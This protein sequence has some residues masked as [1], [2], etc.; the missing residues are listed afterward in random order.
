M[1]Q[2]HLVFVS[3]QPVPSLTPLIDPAVGAR[4]AILVH[5]PERR[6]H[7]L[8]LQ[9]ALARHAVSAQLHP[10]RDGYDL[11]GLREELRD[12]AARHPQ[13]V[14]AN[15]TGGT[16]L[17][18]IAAWEC[19]NR[20]GDRLYYIDIRH[21][22]L[23][24]LRPEAPEQPVADRVQLETYLLAHGRRISPQQPL[25]RDA[26]E[27]SRLQLARQQ[28]LHLARSERK[29]ASEGGQWLEDLVFAEALDLKRSDRKVQDVA[30]QFRLEQSG[31]GQ[32]D[33]QNEIDVAILR[34]NTLHLIECKTGRAGRGG[35]AAKALYKLA[36][37]VEDLGGLRGRGIF[38]TTESLS[39]PLCA[40]ARQL[41]IAI[42]DRSALSDL[43]R[44]LQL[45]LI[46]PDPLHGRMQSEDL[47]SPVV[48][49][50]TRGRLL[51]VQ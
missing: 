2:P 43:S 44:A 41:R 20:E 39:A 5:A 10:L 50:R 19:F 23:R 49:S 29:H 42:I 18:T 3:D 25:R 12:L 11:A 13:G 48:P 24:W 28:A 26:L 14:I 33:I 34:N 21:D 37:L 47:P 22:S 27:P 16:K 9:A 17:M 38:V 51:P 31:K 32:A 4:E 1:S 45:S 6:D 15:I 30:R 7:A 40:R 35:E 46:S 8:W 36:Q